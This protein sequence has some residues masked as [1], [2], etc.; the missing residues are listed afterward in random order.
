MAAT[1]STHQSALIAPHAHR[2]H[3]KVLPAQKLA[4]LRPAQ[5]RVRRF[6]LRVKYRSLPA[7]VRQQRNPIETIA[8]ASVE[9]TAQEVRT[10]P[11]PT[12]PATNS[13]AKATK[14]RELP[15]G[16]QAGE[17]ESS[18]TDEIIDLDASTD[19]IQAHTASSSNETK[20]M[21][22]AQTAQP[23]QQPLR[24]MPAVR[25]TTVTKEKAGKKRPASTAPLE[26]AEDRWDPSVSAR[27]AVNAN[28]EGDGGHPCGCPLVTPAKAGSTNLPPAEEKRRNGWAMSPASRS[29]PG[30]S[31]CLSICQ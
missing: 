31:I 23:A 12:S 29:G 10:A 15:E 21:A 17:T 28:L 25:E 5:Q 14:Q 4:S 26:N 8:S 11:T 22:A 2:T 20:A 1:G 27:T 3:S 13:A 6:H 9:D 18:T 7:K 24:Q 30:L 19:A 16:A